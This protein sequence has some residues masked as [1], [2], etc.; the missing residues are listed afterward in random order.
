MAT[1]PNI[2]TTG[3]QEEETIQTPPVETADA[4]PIQAPPEEKAP[5]TTVNETATNSMMSVQE[6]ANKQASAP[7]P[8]PAPVVE[9]KAPE[10]PAP[11]QANDTANPKST[12]TGANST[13]ASASVSA[14][15]GV[16]VDG[17]TVPSFTQNMSPEELESFRAT[18]G[19]IEKGEGNILAFMAGDSPL[20]GMVMN[21]ALQNMR[22][23]NNSAMVAMKQTLSEQG[24]GGSGAGNAFLASIAR[25]QGVAMGDMMS[26]L[27]IDARNRLEQWNKFGLEYGNKKFDKMKSDDLAMLDYI[28]TRGGSPEEMNEQAG[29]ISE[30]YGY[31]M[32]DFTD[33]NNTTNYNKAKIQ[34]QDKQAVLADKLAQGD[35]EGYMKLEK[36]MIDSGEYKGY[37]FANNT[38]S[39]LDDLMTD[40]ATER[41][42][43]AF[44]ALSYE[45]DFLVKN[46]QGD[47]AGDLFAKSFDV[48]G[49]LNTT[50]QPMTSAQTSLIAEQFKNTTPE[51]QELDTATLGILNALKLTGS[52]EDVRLFAQAEYD[53][54][55]TSVIGKQMKMYLDN[56]S[57][58]DMPPGYADD[59]R[60]ERAATASMFNVNG[61]EPTNEDI[62]K[63]TENL[64]DAHGD[65]RLTELG[66]NLASGMTE[67]EFAEL[68]ITKVDLVDDKDYKE[69][70]ARYD[71]NNERKLNSVNPEHTQLKSQIKALFSDDE[72]FN[73][74]GEIKIFDDFLAGLTA[75]SYTVTDGKIDLSTAL[76]GGGF[77]W[78]DNAQKHNYQDLEG[79]DFTGDYTYEMAQDDPIL[80]VGMDKYDKWKSKLSYDEYKEVYELAKANSKTHSDDTE[81]LGLSGEIDRLANEKSLDV[82]IPTDGIISSSVISSLI[83]GESISSYADQRLVDKRALL[84]EQETEALRQLITGENGVYL[85]D[86]L[87]S[88]KAIPD[89]TGHLE[90]KDNKLTGIKNINFEATPYRGTRYLAIAGDVYEVIAM[91]GVDSYS[92]KAVDSEFDN[93]IY[94]R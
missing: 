66:E 73:S 77:P 15:S 44:D 22:A 81:L 14:G 67:E 91:D 79:N 83:E 56:P 70:Y 24:L 87:I 53:K 17:N 74:P 55:P 72:Y 32:P 6:L 11:T 1:L 18:Q 10:V 47:I 68:G 89:Y 80:S 62:F 7:A 38:P 52:R 21:K 23:G 49:P 48:G 65:S 2:N 31:A 61:N 40:Y 3:I 45:T 60:K 51:Q 35:F 39:K 36:E 84:G 19:M 78:E 59:L 58:I 69:L 54:D 93:V 26:T 88:S 37:A 82:K 33:P 12:G 9:V 92:I 25:D 5:E 50:G 41:K 57:L 20:D 42:Q 43:T 71:L 76:N 94:K 4:P 13:P 46:G 28:I 8:T 29:L 75:G 34:Y 16:Q 85:K 90:I 86:K 30:K 27:T 64:V 63:Y